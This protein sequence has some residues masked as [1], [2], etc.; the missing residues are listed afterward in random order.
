MSLFR[1]VIVGSPK[2]VTKHGAPER[3]EDL[4][5]HEYL[6]FRSPTGGAL[7]VGARTRQVH[8]A[9]PIRGDNVTNR[10]PSA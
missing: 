9:A 1:F 3:P 8:V 2:Y 10:S 7:C 5:R 6:T 4:H